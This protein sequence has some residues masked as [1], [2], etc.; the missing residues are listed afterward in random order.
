MISKEGDVDVALSEKEMRERGIPRSYGEFMEDL[1]EMGE[2]AL[3]AM[4]RGRESGDP[5][6]EFTP[7]EADVLRRGGLDLSTDDSGGRGD[8][9]GQTAAKYALML[10]S[11]LSTMEAAERIGVSEGRVR[12]RLKEGSLY[13]IGTPRGHRLPAFQFTQ[14]GEVPNVGA[15][16]RSLDRDLHPVAAQNWLTLPDPDLYLAADEELPVS[17]REWLLAGG[18]PDAVVPP[19]GEL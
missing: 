16:L 10:A 1:R 8:A 3:L 17:P 18:S 5:G 13:G 14:S 7:E 6:R 19:M 12:Q 15:V 11:A 2:A 4:P 9:L